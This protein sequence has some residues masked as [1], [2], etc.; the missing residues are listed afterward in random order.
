MP[1]AE[2]DPVSQWW[3]GAARRLLARAYAG[4]G[5]W[6]ATRLVDPS[7]RQVARARSLGIDLAGPD[8][9]R[10]LPGRGVNARDRWSRA[11]VRAVYF[12]HRW[13]SGKPGGGWREARRASPRSASAIEV[14][15]GRRVPGRGLIPA[16]RAVRVR[17]RPGGGAAY[18]AVGRKPE[19]ERI[20][21]NDGQP[22]DR[23][24]FIDGP[25]RDW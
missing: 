4:R 23:F 7:P 25:S 20:W 14:E 5:S 10:A 17:T 1:A 13:Y 24:S 19:T 8:P 2:R 9:V 3:D 12:Q 21:G 6:V 22:A 11:F 16:G 18:R 15:L